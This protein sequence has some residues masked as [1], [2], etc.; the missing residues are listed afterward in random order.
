MTNA[1]DFSWARP[2]VPALGGAGIK[3]VGRY[4]TG[5][6]KAATFAEIASYDSAGI[7][8]WFVAENAAND[9]DSGH[10][11]GILMAAAAAFAVADVIGAT[12]GAVQ[13]RYFAVDENI[14]PANPA[15]FGALQRC[16]GY[17]V[18]ISRVTD[19]ALVGAYGNGA[20]LNYLGAVGLASWFWQSSS[21]SFAGNGSTIPAAHIR[22]GFGGPLPGTDADALLQ[23]DVGQFPRP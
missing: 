21:S 20:L 16:I 7:V 6:G 11:G 17:F 4:L 5:P 12:A 10:S 3:A 18:G 13:P 23:G 8:S 2:G 19:P 14:D 22:Q 1:I 9:S 15:H